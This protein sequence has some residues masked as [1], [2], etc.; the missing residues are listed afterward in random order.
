MNQKKLIKKNKKIKDQVSTG[1][2]AFTFAILAFLLLYS[3]EES[4]ES[5]GH[6]DFTIEELEAEE[7]KA[8]KEKNYRTAA[9]IHDLIEQKQKQ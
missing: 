6:M 7:A 1:V 4:E 9:L 8:V 2:I 5:S 3:D